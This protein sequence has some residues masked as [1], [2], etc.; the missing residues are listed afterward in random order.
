MS[1]DEARMKVR[2]RLEELVGVSGAEILMDRPPGGWSDLVTDSNDHLYQIL[3]KRILGS[4]F[5]I[6]GTW[7]SEMSNDQ[8]KTPTL[9]DPKNFNFY[10]NIGSL[11]VRVGT[12]ST[13]NQRRRVTL[14][15]LGDTD[16][17]ELF[18]VVVNSMMGTFAALVRLNH[19]IY[20][21]NEIFYATSPPE[22]PIVLDTLPSL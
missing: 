16:G 19:T 12:C 8:W 15:A 5:T 18:V 20:F 9:I 21:T 14:S 7:F 6:Y 11:D 13:D 10:D 17:N 2:K 1:V 3:V 4:N 22:T